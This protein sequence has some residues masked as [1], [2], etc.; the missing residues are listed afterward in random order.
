MLAA[1]VGER[2]IFAEVKHE[3][4][5]TLRIFEP[6]DRCDVRVI[7]RGEHLRFVFKAD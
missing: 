5:D 1:G 7:E 6:V 2:R 3:R 4:L